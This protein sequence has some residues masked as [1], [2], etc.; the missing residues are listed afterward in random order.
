ME[1]VGEEVIYTFGFILLLLVAFII[2]R[3]SYVMEP[4]TS[5]VAHS[6]SINDQATSETIAAEAGPALN[7]TRTSDEIP[8]NSISTEQVSNSPLPT[9]NESLPPSP[10]QPS[11][12]LVT[13]RI[14][15]LD[16]RSRLAQTCLSET[17]GAFRRKHLA[18]EI[19]PSSRVRLIFNGHELVR[20]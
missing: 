15:F 13:V 18:S 19:T 6:S 17:L 2:W 1:G 14:K 5:N 20:N 12:P 8:S 10:V 9:E 16:E 4:M 11:G 7:R 3:M